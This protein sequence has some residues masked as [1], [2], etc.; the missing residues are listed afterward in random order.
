METY[1]CGKPKITGKCADC[2]E[3]KVV[4]S[5]SNPICKYCSDIRKGKRSPGEKRA[6]GARGTYKKYTRKAAAPAAPCVFSVDLGNCPE[7]IEK[8]RQRAAEQMRT[9]EAQIAW[10]LKEN[11]L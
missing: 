10:E 4:I 11:I 8:L 7:V 3:R 9:V 2:G 5:K 1:K 6:G